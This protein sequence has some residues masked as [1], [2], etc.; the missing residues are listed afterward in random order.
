M[1]GHC[2]IFMGFHP[3]GGAYFIHSSS[4]NRCIDTDD[5][6]NQKWRDTLV[7]ARRD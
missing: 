7:G 5:L 4:N 6:R 3:D 2:G 1:I